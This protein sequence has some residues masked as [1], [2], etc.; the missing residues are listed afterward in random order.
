MKGI[1]AHLCSGV[2]FFT[3]WSISISVS[4]SMSLS[5]V[6]SMIRFD[7]MSECQ[8][9]CFV[10]SVWIVACGLRTVRSSLV[11]AEMAGDHQSIE[12]ET[13]S[14]SCE[15]DANAKRELGYFQKVYDV[16]PRQ[17]WGQSRC[18]VLGKTAFIPFFLGGAVHNHH[19][20][21][22]CPRIEITVLL[23]RNKEN[24]QSCKHMKKFI[25]HFWQPCLQI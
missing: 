4:I 21:S 22:N 1:S 15:R 8:G 17:P 2:F 18:H 20:A 10:I 3:G 11:A 12:S 7:A 23:K 13:S 16:N 25:Q 9:G 19:H 24:M 14:M 5:L 6:K